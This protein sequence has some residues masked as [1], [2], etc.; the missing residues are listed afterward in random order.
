MTLAER[1]EVDKQL[2]RALELLQ[3]DRVK[4]RFTGMALPASRKAV[5]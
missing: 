2:A 3:Q 1:L 5:G 4:S